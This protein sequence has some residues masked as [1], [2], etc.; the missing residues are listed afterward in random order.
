ML[1]NKITRFR[2]TKIFVEAEWNRQAEL[3]ELYKQY[4]NGTYKA[5]ITAK[6]PASRYDYYLKNEIMQLAFRTGKKAGVP[7][8]YGFDYIHTFFPYDSVLQAMKQAHQ[9]PLI[10]R[11]QANSKAVETEQNR[12]KPKNS[13]PLPHAVATRLQYPQKLGRK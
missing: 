7:R 11:I 8:I 1:T 4:L 2:P 6:F 3:D 13:C 9:E 10:R 12:A 5:Y